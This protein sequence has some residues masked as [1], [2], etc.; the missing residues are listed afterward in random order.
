MAAPTLTLTYP[1]NNDT[2]IPIGAVIA[3]SFDRGIDLT[4]A[5]SNVVLY[6]RDYDV[7][8]G[9]DSAMWIDRQTGD[10]PFFLSS[11]GFSGLVPTEVSLVYL[12]S[13]GAVLNPQPTDIVDEADALARG[14][15]S[16]ILVTPKN[17]L[18]ADVQYTLHVIGNTDATSN[19]ISSRTVFDPIPDAGNVSTTSNVFVYG[20]YT[21]STSDSIVIEI[22]TGGDIGTAKYRW[23]FASAPSE[24]KSG[25][26]T[27]RRFRKLVES[28][29]VQI[30]FTGSSFSAGDSWTV[31]VEPAEYLA[32]STQISFTTNDGTYSAAP[33]SPS[34]PA[35]A[36][37]P[38]TILP[39][40]PGAPVGSS[41]T[42]LSVLEMQPRDTSYHN[43]LST[44]EITIVF[45]E[46]VDPAT[47]TQQ[48]V[49]IYKMPVTGV[50]G[51]TPRQEELQKILTLTGDTLTIEI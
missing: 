49:R 11:P 13:L 26:V 30:R 31:A 25:L 14:Y 47:I 18:A 46:D 29:G 37:V 28:N 41:T 34:T 6:G 42:S 4:T 39:P 44:R 50:Y 36:G 7:T 51:G 40:A 48:S 19:G 23:Y 9:P 38:A 10:D 22:T 8:S 12:D 33:D 17:P 32:T 5:K 21:G 43:K 2:G 16:Q 35:T 1:A 3:L 24:V 27:S 15:T 45:S 20:S